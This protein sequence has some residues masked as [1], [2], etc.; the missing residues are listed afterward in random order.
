MFLFYF[1]SKFFCNFSIPR[2]TERDMIK[3]VYRSSCKVPVILV[4]FQWNLDFLD[5]FSKNTIIPNF[6]RIRP[7]EADLFHADRRTSRS[8]IFDFRNFSNEP[9]IHNNVYERG[10][11]YRNS[12]CP[13]ALEVVGG[14]WGE[15][16][17]SRMAK[18]PT[19]VGWLGSGQSS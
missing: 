8:S 5:R 9:K 16:F 1:L 17:S 14:I 15:I 3:N 4:R 10:S 19:V 11:G 6:M 12:I 2:R 13:T 18:R 7:V